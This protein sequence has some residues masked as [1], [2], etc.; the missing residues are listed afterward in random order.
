V[1]TTTN[2]II[3]V[4]LTVTAIFTVTVGGFM[5]RALANRR[6]VPGHIVRFLRGESGLEQDLNDIAEDIRNTPA[7]AQLQPWGV[8]TLRL[9]REEKLQTNGYAQFYWDQP[10]AVKL[11]LQERPEFIKHQ[12][13]ETN[14][15]GEEEPE[16]FIVF[17]T[18][19]QPEAVAIGWY[20]YGIQ[21]GPPEYRLSYTSCYYAPYVQAKPGIYVYGNYK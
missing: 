7:L 14:Q 3:I 2:K 19:K 9:F 6:S 12:W 8:E 10:P 17:N 11:A 4:L 21:I 1:H 20:M 16:I 13:G 15:D 18:N 5:W